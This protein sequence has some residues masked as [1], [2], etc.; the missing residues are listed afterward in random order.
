MSLIELLSKDSKEIDWDTIKTIVN[1]DTSTIE[2]KNK[3]GNLPLHLA[4]NNGASTDVIRLLVEAYPNAV[5]EKNYDGD[6]PL[7]IACEKDASITVI[8]L[9]TLH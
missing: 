7:Q 5:K 2:E 4:C 1:N 8:T 9:L 3:D 6:L